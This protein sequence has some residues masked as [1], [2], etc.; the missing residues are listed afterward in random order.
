MTPQVKLDFCCGC[1]ENN[2]HQWVCGHAQHNE[3]HTIIKAE[4]AQTEIRYSVIVYSFVYTNMDYMVI[5]I[6]LAA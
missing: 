6:V 4:S 2:S 1:N 5:I 3:I